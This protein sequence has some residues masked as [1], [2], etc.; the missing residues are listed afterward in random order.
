MAV[1]WF[2]PESH[3]PIS[4]P[5]KIRVGLF[6][7]Q[8]CRTWH[9]AQSYPAQLK[10]AHPPSLPVSAGPVSAEQ[11]NQDFASPVTLPARPC[12]N[13]P[14]FLLTACPSSPSSLFA[15]HAWC[16]VTEEQTRPSVLQR[17]AQAGRLVYL[18][19]SAPTS[20][21]FENYQGRLQALAK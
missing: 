6:H 1:A 9:S 2:K 11:T 13:L 14:L 21:K 19:P 20:V 8:P 5:I 15:P 7:C 16:R 17:A 12:R 3:L 4:A 18:L 10:T